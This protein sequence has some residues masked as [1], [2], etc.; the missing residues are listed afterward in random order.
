MKIIDSTKIKDARMIKDIPMGQVF[1]GFIGG[2]A[3][4][5]LK[6]YEVVINLRDPSCTWTNSDTVVSDYQPV[7]ATLTLENL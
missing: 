1:K 6:A 7:K 5:F 2:C 4:V 3:S